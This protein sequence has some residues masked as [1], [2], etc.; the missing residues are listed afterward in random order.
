MAQ[1]LPLLQPFSA[2]AASALLTWQ[3]MNNGR[4]ML[5]DLDG[6][7]AIVTAPQPGSAGRSSRCWPAMACACARRPRSTVPEGLPASRG[8]LRLSGRCQRATAL[9]PISVSRQDFGSY[10][11]LCANAGVSSMAPV[12]PDRRGLGGQFRRQCRGVFLVTSSPSGISRR[13]PPGTIVNTASLASEVGA[14]LAHYSAA[15]FAVF[16]SPRR[17]PARGWTRASGELRLP[18][19]SDRHAGRIVWEAEL[20]GNPE[21][22]TPN[23]RADPPGMEARGRRQGRAVPRL[24]PVAVHHSEAIASPAACAWTDDAPVPGRC[25]AACDLAL[26]SAMILLPLLWVRVG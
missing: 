15:K 20:R 10:D 1:W 13:R 3:V 8:G 11:I 7:R 16:G 9:P 21:A 19:S 5:L 26:F 25:P 6:K 4:A 14:Y 22:V 23:C 2:P 17:W 12:E 18:P 24:R